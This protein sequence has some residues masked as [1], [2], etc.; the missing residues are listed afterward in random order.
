MLKAAYKAVHKADPRAKVVLTGLHNQ[1]W[2][3][4]AQL[5]RG[6]IKGYY[7][8]LALHPYT[9]SVARVLE[10]V[11]LNR[12]VLKRN[13][14]AKKPIYLSEMVFSA[15]KGKIPKQ[16]QFGIE[17]TPSGQAKLLTKLYRGVIRHRRELN[18]T[19]TYWARWS[20]FYRG[21]STFEY[22]GLVRRTGADVF[23]ST[24]ALAA[25]TRTSRRYEGCK[26]SNDARRC[27]KR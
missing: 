23:S 20:S 6:G 14:E 3:T 12:R 26:K 4:L 19:R 16:N 22:S 8:K 27:A 17:T 21:N 9:K 15:A 18:I 7:D 1:S 10:I 25:F 13:G 24:P 5:Y 2:T 11:R